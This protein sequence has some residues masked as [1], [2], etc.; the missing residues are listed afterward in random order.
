MNL[1]PENLASID[2]RAVSALIANGE[3]DR[4]LHRARMLARSIEWAMSDAGIAPT[5]V[6]IHD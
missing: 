3:W 2:A 1:N 6:H 4:A 5:P